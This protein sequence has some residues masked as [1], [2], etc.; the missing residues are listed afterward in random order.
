MSYLIEDSWG[1]LSAHALSLLQYHTSPNLWNIPLN[2]RD[3]ESQKSTQ[4]QYCYENNFY[5]AGP[6]KVSGTLSS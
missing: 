5:I 3:S 1:F 6:L 2:I 4:W